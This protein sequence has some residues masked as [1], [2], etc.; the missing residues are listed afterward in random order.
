MK[1]ILA[2]LVSILILSACAG[3]SDNDLSK[4]DSSCGQGCSKNYSECLGKFTFFP[5][6]SQHQC[7]DAFRQCAQSCPL[8][9]ASFVTSDKPSVTEKLKELDDLLKNGLINERD[10][11]TKKQE[12]LKSM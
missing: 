4:V 10:Y 9:S 3:T 1:A 7:T 5:I 11:E 8:R 2:G 6:Q 12:I